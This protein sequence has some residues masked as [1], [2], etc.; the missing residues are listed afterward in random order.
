[1]TSRSATRR[2]SS[3]SSAPPATTTMAMG[4]SG[5]SFNNDGDVDVTFAPLPGQV[6]V[7]GGGGV[8]FLTGRGG[9]G[10]GLA[11]AGNVTLVGGDLGDELNGGNGHDELTGGGGDDVLNGNAGDD[12]LEGD[13]GNDKLSGGE[14]RTSSSAAPARTRS[15]AASATTCSLALRRPGRHAPSTAEATR[16]SPTTTQASTRRRAPSE[17]AIPAAPTESCSYDAGTQGRDGADSAR[18][19]RDAQSGGERRAALRVRA[20]PPAR[21]ATTTNTDSIQVLGAPGAT[22]S[23]RWTCPR[24]SSAPASPRSSTCRRSR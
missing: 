8:N 10:A 2:T 17:T 18:L 12:R 13:G 3:S 21:A 4:A 6:E 22:E 16:T 20:R 9:W 14:G 1:M 19:G 5:F 7:M 24:A 11:Y 15:T 23:S